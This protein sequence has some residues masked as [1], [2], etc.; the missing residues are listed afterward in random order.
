M[1]SKQV[2]NKTFLSN[3]Y[4]NGNEYVDGHP[5]IKPGYLSEFYKMLHVMAIMPNKT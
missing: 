5:Q 1:G 3:W 4:V 2:Q